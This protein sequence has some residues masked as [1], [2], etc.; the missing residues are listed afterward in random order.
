M[1]FDPLA[2]ARTQFAEWLWKNE[3]EK[4]IRRAHD[5]VK[6][7]KINTKPTDTQPFAQAN[8]DKINTGVKDSKGNRR[9]EFT[10]HVDDCLYC[11]TKEH[12]ELTIACSVISCEDILG[13]NTKYQE[14]IISDEK[15]NAQYEET[16]VL[17][18]HQPDSRAMA[19]LLSPRRR[20]KIIAV[21]QDG[22][23]HDTRERAT[24][25]E[26][27]EINSLLAN[28]GEYFLWVRAQLF[29]I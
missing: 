6:Q 26:I 17:L 18:G 8:K 20:E 22:R 23:W 4:T 9:S 19:V 16:R 28:A 14:D 10:A 2:V 21:I 29:N 12:L 25:V 27:A 11:D 3:P 7:M 24:I 15:F 13:G 1:N 5:F